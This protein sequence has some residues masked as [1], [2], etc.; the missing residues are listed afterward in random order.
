MS[1]IS[2]GDYIVLMTCHPIAES[3][4]LLEKAR[5]V[6]VAMETVEKNKVIVDVLRG[7]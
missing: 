2:G 4:I 3:H 6:N 5:S 7:F 1:L